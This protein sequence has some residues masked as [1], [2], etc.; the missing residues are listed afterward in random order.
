MTSDVYDL[1]T[2]LTNPHSKRPKAKSKA[3]QKQATRTV[4]E[5]TKVFTYSDVPFLCLSLPY[6]KSGKE[7]MTQKGYLHPKGP[8]EW[9]WRIIH[10]MDCQNTHIMVTDD[11]HPVRRGK[12]WVI[13]SI[14][15]ARS[16]RETCL[17]DFSTVPCACLVLLFFSP[18]LPLDIMFNQMCVLFFSALS[19]LYSLGETVFTK[20]GQFTCQVERAQMMKNKGT[21]AGSLWCYM[22]TLDKN[23][24]QQLIHL[25]CDNGSNN[26]QRSQYYVLP[27][28]ASFWWRRWRWVVPV[29]Y[30]AQR[31]LPQVHVQRSCLHL[32]RGEWTFFAI[33]V[34]SFNMY[35]VF[36]K[37]C[38]CCQW[39]SSFSFCF[40]ILQTY[41]EKCQTRANPSVDYCSLTG[42][43][44]PEAFPNW[45]E[46][47]V[48]Q[49]FKLC[50]FTEAKII[51]LLVGGP[52]DLPTSS[53]WGRKTDRLRHRLL[54][55]FS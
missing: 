25:L 34:K 54:W 1:L 27:P 41:S 17:H 10:F 12:S 23:V 5:L 3:T 14:C 2:L 35:L 43:V 18:V 29:H 16:S 20:C 31:V 47:T 11:N 6:L 30:G 8:A 52:T 32:Q 42:T 40:S 33:S 39:G 13:H 19:Y 28:P 36:I 7:G 50:V 9:K 48:N 37:H 46:N 53:T 26:Q 38:T 21:A 22:I 55:G 24:K 15:P 45:V 4:K 51:E 49:H 44:P